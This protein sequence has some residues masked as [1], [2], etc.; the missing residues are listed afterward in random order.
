MNAP[1]SIIAVVP[2][3]TQSEANAREHFHAKAARAKR[4]RAAT[5]LVLRRHAIAPAPLY[6]VRLTRVAA[7][8]RHAS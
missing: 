7:T 5:E 6:L 1:R 2:V 4:Q 3:R 8:S